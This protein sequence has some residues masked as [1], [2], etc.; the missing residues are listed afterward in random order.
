[1][2][3]L[4]GQGPVVAGERIS[5]TLQRLQRVAAMV[6][7]FSSVGPERQ[8]PVVAGERFGRACQVLQ[9]V[10]SIVVGLG[11]IR[12]DRQ[13]PLEARERLGWAL[14][15]AQHDAAIVERFGVARLQGQRL[16]VARECL[17]AA[18]ERIEHEPV[19]QQHRRSL[20]IRLQR[21]ADQRKGLGKTPLLVAQNAEHLQPV[22]I[23]GLGREQLQIQPL[24]FHKISPAM[25]IDSFSE[26][27]R[28]IVHAWECLRRA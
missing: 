28:Q 23:T 7:N 9:S 24:G 18:R 26:R 22:E 21:R 12:P 5:R 8:S 27:L 11:I 2:V 4:D 3:R 10:P 13:R 17:L 6:E 25:E 16:V 14:Q 20:W 1:M 15:A 19:V